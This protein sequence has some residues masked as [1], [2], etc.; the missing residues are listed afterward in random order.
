MLAVVA[1]I[2]TA[3]TRARPRFLAPTPPAPLAPLVS[4]V[5]LISLAP[6]APLVPPA[7]P[8]G[9]EWLSLMGQTMAGDLLQIRS[10]SSES[11][12]NEAAMNE[13]L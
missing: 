13:R 12:M 5:S 10:A 9:S 3:L 4:L 11:A 6:P 1:E 2:A 7:P 8:R